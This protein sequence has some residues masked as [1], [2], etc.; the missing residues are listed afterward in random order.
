M[1]NE[2]KV[3]EQAPKTLRQQVMEKLSTRLLRA[4]DHAPP[5]DVL[6][7]LQSL[8]LADRVRF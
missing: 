1:S 5:D 8:E 2:Q 4:T 6:K 3:P 7:L